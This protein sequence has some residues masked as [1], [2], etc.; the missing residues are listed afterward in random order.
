M[1]VPKTLTNIIIPV[2]NSRQAF[3]FPLPTAWVVEL[4]LHLDSIDWLSYQSAT[5]ITKKKNVLLFRYEAVWQY[6]T[7]IAVYLKKKRKETSFSHEEILSLMFFPGLNY[8]KSKNGFVIAPLN[9]T[10]RKRIKTNEMNLSNVFLSYAS[11]EY[12]WKKHFVLQNEKNRKET[13]HF[14]HQVCQSNAQTYINY[15]LLVT[16]AKE[17]YFTGKIYCTQHLFSE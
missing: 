3:V 5:K 6:E 4:N 7:T 12:Q 11:W 15:S 14:D 8:S 1:A 17:V 2:S 13:E 10:K 16:S 9:R